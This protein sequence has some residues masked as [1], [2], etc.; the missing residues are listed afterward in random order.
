MWFAGSDEPGE[1]ECREDQFKCGEEGSQLCIAKTDVCQNQYVECE[2]NDN[3][4]C[5]M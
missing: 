3:I 4:Q 2:N 1:C 5:S